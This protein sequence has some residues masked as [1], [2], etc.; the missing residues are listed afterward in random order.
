MNT[1]RL[2]GFTGSDDLNRLARQVA[3][4][5]GTFENMLLHRVPKSVSVVASE[6]WMV[7]HLHEDFDAVERRMATAG[8]GRQRVEEFH[9]FLF[10]SSLESLRSHVRRATGVML[11]GAV[12]HVDTDSCMVLKTFSTH[13][14]VDLF[15]L[16]GSVPGLGVPVNHHRHADCANGHGSVRL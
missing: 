6:E 16:G 15:V 1:N 14:S 13:P 8:D 10:E 11:R 2:T 5:T 7:V 9:R 3:Q 12:A 4:A